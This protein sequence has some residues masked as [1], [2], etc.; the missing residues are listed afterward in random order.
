MTA[1]KKKASPLEDQFAAQ[2]AEAN[3]P[4]E[5]EYQA[6]ADQGRKFRWDFYL[7]PFL[8]IEV[9]GGIWMGRRGG[10]SS[11]F[12]ISRDY[13]KLN[14]ATVHGYSCLLL[15]AQDVKS[16]Q[17]LELVQDFLMNRSFG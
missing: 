16:G 11:P 10:H 4:F 5:R 9:N 15:T 7:R 6:L 1:K 3:L 14:L 17:G 2:L 8:L 12:G 13:E